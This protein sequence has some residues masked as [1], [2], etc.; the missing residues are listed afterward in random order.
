MR[1]R[2]LRRLQAISVKYLNWGAAE[3]HE[4]ASD[5][6][7]AGTFARFGRVEIEP[8]STGCDILTRSGNVE[9]PV[10]GWSSWQPLDL[11]APLPRHRAA[12]LQ[13]K[14]VLHSSGKPGQRWRQRYLPVNSAPVIDEL[15]VVPGARINPQAN[16]SPESELLI[17]RSRLRIRARRSPLTANSSSQPLQG[18]RRIARLSPFLGGA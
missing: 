4:Y 9:Q 1:E 8:G 15:V 3:T 17:L 5:V 13:W 2:S 12:F 16:Y 18:A 6:L 11:M 7:D 10:R 14:A